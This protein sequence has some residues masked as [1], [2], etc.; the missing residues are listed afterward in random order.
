VQETGQT[1]VM[2]THDPRSASIADRIL[3]LADGNIVKDLP[4][5]EP[6]EVIAAM[7]EIS[8]T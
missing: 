5:S 4:R 2:V 3:F 6:R 8:S 7:E 1:T